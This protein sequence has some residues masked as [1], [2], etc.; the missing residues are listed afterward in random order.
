M[1]AFE[2]IVADVLESQGFWTRTN[3]KV[4]L[5]KQQKAKINRPTTPRWDLDVVAYK[6]GSNTLQIVEC[7]SYLDSNGVSFR[8]FDPDTGGTDRFKLF[9][10]ENLCGVIVDALVNDL[11]AH[12]LLRGRPT[13]ELCLAAANIQESSFDKLKDLFDENAWVLYDHDWLLAGIKAVAESGYEDSMLSIMAK[14]LGR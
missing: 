12:Q 14:L 10:D 6:P 2:T 4:P 8:G 9:N 7:K 11:N 3:Y 1:N 13:V 5:S